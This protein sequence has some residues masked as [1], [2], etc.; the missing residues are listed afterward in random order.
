MTSKAMTS[1]MTSSRLAGVSHEGMR[2]CCWR[3][4]LGG[5]FTEP[6]ARSADILWDFALASV[7]PV[8][9]LGLQARGMASAILR[10][11]P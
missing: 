5:A 8:A 6:L 1:S 9:K 2:G 4:G 7:E 11:E 10:L 3:G